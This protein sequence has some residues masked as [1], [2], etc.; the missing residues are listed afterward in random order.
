M[1][2]NHK[3]NSSKNTYYYFILNYHLALDGC[4]FFSVTVNDAG[5]IQLLLLLRIVSKVWISMME[6]GHHHVQFPA[7]STILR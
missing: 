5:L 7:F 6:Q 4:K 1:K 2:M 3:E